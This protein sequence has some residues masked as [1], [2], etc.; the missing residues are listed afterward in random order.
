MATIVATAMV[1]ANMIRVRI[2]ACSWLEGLSPDFSIILTAIAP[3]VVTTVA[4]IAKASVTGYFFRMF[5]TE[6]SHLPS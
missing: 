2:F 1:D 4:R 6:S 3:N 5:D